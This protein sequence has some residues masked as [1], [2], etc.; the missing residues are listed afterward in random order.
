MSK[1]LTALVTSSCVDILILQG[2]DSLQGELR[3]Q[4]DALLNLALLGD[5]I[6]PENLPQSHPILIYSQRPYLISRGAA[7]KSLRRKT[8]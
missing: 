4:S 6:G 3:F 1:G 2:R 7:A 8:C 5:G